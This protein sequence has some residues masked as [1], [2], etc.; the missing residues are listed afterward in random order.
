[1]RYGGLGEEGW[2]IR[3][4]WALVC[5]CWGSG[6]GTVPLLDTCLTKEKGASW[7]GVM[8]KVRKLSGGQIMYALESQG[9]EFGGAGVRSNYSFVCCNRERGINTLRL[10]FLDYW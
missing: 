10:W 2:R 3:G 8:S 7:G 6:V 4:K 5:H 9:R 1:M